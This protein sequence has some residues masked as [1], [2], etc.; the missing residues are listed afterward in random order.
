MKKIIINIKAAY[1]AETPKIARIVGHLGVAVLAIALAVTAAYPLLPYQFTAVL[2]SHTAEV[3]GAIC[4][5]VT[6]LS[7]FTFMKQSFQEAQ[8][9]LKDVSD[10]AILAPNYTATTTQNITPHIADTRCTADMNEDTVDK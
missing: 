9:L 5:L 3:I 7:K 6:V 2:P 1:K 4:F 10:N 8:A